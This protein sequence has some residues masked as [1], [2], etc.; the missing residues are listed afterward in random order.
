MARV[1]GGQA[2][3]VRVDALPEVEFG[4]HVARID[5]QSEEYRGDVTYPV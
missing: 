1:A 2:A 4:G 5:L 3:V